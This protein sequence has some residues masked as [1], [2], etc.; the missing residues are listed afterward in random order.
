MHIHVSSGS[1]EAKFW[2]EPELELA[3]NH[4]FSRQELKSIE[5]ILE[6]FYGELI[7]AWHYHFDD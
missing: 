5:I 4:R 6:E 7:S 2:L 1:G 3:H